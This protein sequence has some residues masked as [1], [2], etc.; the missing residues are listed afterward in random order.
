MSVN[1][2]CSADSLIVR[3]CLFEVQCSYTTNLLSVGIMRMIKAN[4][5][6]MDVFFCEAV[7]RKDHR[8]KCTAEEV[9]RAQISTRHLPHQSIRSKDKVNYILIS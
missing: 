3:C 1:V 6:S 9:K 2:M 8:M 4:Y 5:R 7:G